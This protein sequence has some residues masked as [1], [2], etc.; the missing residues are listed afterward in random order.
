MQGVPRAS[1]S[2]EFTALACPV[3]TLNP[4]PIE[5]LVLIAVIY[6]ER[7]YGLRASDFGCRLVGLRVL[8]LGF[9][10]KESMIIRIL[11]VALL[12]STPDSWKFKVSSSCLCSTVLGP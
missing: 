7:I 12:E 4:K 11:P 3:S 1:G 9:R 10:V 6:V 8:S 5:Y 2:C